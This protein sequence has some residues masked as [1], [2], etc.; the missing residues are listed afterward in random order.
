MLQSAPCLHERQHRDVYNLVQA[1][2]RDLTASVS[3]RSMDRSPFSIQI[4]PSTTELFAV[5][6]RRNGDHSPGTFP[7]RASAQF[8]NAPFGNNGIDVCARSRDGFHV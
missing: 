6:G 4:R 7:K 3:I 2:G 5:L 1:E 8:G